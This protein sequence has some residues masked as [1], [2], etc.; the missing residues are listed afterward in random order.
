MLKYCTYCQWL[1]VLL[2]IKLNCTCSLSDWPWPVVAL[3]WILWK[4][5]LL[6]AWDMQGLSMNTP[7]WVT[8]CL[9]RMNL[10]SIELKPHGNKVLLLFLS[11]VSAE[12]SLKASSL[13]ICVHIAEASG[14]QANI[15]L[16]STG[17]GEIHLHWEVWEPPLRDPAHQG[18][19]QAHAHPDQG[20]SEGWAAGCEKCHRGWWVL[21]M[22]RTC[23]NSS[24][25]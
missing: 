24:Q 11:A 5:S 22:L 3:P 17:R 8:K 4:I 16:F 19:Q 21:I 20:C 7:W 25:N 23:R 1:W 14:W 9:E 6:T 15:T 18:P 13:W 10:K 2:N 12:L